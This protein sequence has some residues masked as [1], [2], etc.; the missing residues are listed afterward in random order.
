[1]FVGL[2]G[3]HQFVLRKFYSVINLEAGWPAIAAWSARKEKFE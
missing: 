1:L 3:L 2:E